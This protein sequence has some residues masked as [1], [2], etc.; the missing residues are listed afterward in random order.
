[1]DVLPMGGFP[2]FDLDCAR[3][4]SAGADYPVAVWGTWLVA[5]VRAAAV[6]R[7]RR[8]NGTNG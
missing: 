4:G 3:S 1:M 8:Q 7:I 2:E 6:A 5:A